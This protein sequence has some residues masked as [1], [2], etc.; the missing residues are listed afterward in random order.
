MAAVETAD[1]ARKLD[2]RGLHTEADAEERH[3][4]FSCLTDRF[5]HPLDAP[6]A[7]TAR[8]QEPVEAAEDLHGTLVPDKCLTR[9]PG[10]VDADVVRDAAVYQR[11]E[12]ALVA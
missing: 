6:D 10:D 3:S 1:V 4:G 11:F 2:D 7:E 5:D 9:D 12:H 8:Y